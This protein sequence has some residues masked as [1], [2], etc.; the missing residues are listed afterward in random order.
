MS[1]KPLQVVDLQLQTESLREQRTHSLGHFEHLEL[2]RLVVQAG[3]RLPPHRAACIVTLQC[4]IGQT[5]LH[6]DAGEPIRLAA[7]QLVCLAKGESHAI[8]GVTD[9][10]LLLT[11]VGDPQQAAASNAQLDGVD[12]AS[13]ESFPASDPPAQTT[14]IKKGP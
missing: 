1:L 2:I 9:A 12:E 3:E 4:L 11:I 10:A 7:G 5:L 6:R 8:E 13:L 14:I